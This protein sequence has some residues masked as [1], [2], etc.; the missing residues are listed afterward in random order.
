MV[1]GQYSEHRM[2]PISILNS[3]K[4][5]PM[6]GV[7]ICGCIGRWLEGSILCLLEW[8]ATF[9]FHIPIIHLPPK[10]ERYT[11]TFFFFFKLILLVTNG[12]LNTSIY[13]SSPPTSSYN[14]VKESENS[15][16]MKKIF[17]KNW[18][19]V[20]KKVENMYSGWRSA[21]KC[22]HPLAK[23]AE[24]KCLVENELSSW[25]YPWTYQ[26]NLRTYHS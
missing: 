18:K 3:P 16:L 12:R 22:H 10:S 4:D 20:V 9:S 26:L 7:G 19:K 8:Q 21:D 2:F 6:W 11:E 1:W 23:K 14:E 25:T 17:K 5:T 24:P 15:K 13:L